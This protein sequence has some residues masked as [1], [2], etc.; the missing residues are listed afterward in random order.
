MLSWFSTYW[1]MLVSIQ[2]VNYQFRAHDKAGRYRCTPS[3]NSENITTTHDTPQGSIKQVSGTWH[4]SV[5]MINFRIHESYYHARVS[6]WKIMVT[7]HRPLEDTLGLTLAC[8]EGPNLQYVSKTVYTECKT[9]LKD[10]P[11]IKSH[12]SCLNIAEKLSRTSWIIEYYLHL[13]DIMEI[14]KVRK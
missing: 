7:W 13:R 4:A 12:I 6:F 3:P 5:C 10:S 11:S 8:G 9:K 2:L 1:P 14:L